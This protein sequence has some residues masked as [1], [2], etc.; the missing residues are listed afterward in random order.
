MII[1]R[2]TEL[3]VPIIPRQTSNFMHRVLMMVH[4]TYVKL[5][6]VLSFFIRP[7]EL[8]SLVL[9]PLPLMISHSRERYPLGWPLRS[10]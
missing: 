9:L 10:Q 5:V 7:V 4:L 6:P 2:M 3:G 8:F 1:Q